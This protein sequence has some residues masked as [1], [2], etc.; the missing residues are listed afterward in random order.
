MYV[1]ESQTQI[2]VMNSHSGKLVSCFSRSQME[3][4]ISVQL[5]SLFCKDLSQCSD[6]WYVYTA[7]CIPKES[8]YPE[9]IKCN[10]IIKCLSEKI[11]DC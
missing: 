6:K 11:E 2:I 3:N 4:Y 8:E 10:E 7:V 9:E 5:F 1:W